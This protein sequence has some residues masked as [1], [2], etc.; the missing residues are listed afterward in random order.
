M[1]KSI[2]M[3]FAGACSYGILSTFVKLAYHEGY[4]IAEIAFLQAFLGMA[5]L[6]LLRLF[7]KKNK[8]IATTTPTKSVWLA[9]TLAG[10]ALGMTSFV[11]YLSVQY[12]PASIAIVALMQFTWI[13]ILLDW[14]FFRKTPTVLQLL[15]IA[16][17]LTGTIMASGM[18]S[19]QTTGLSVKGIVYALASAFLYGIYIV[20]SSKIKT[21]VP[22]LTKSSVM[23]MGSAVLLFTINA[24][25]LLTQSHFDTGLIKWVILLALFGTVIPPLLFSNGIPNIGAGYSAILMSAELPVA[26]ICSQLILKEHIDFYQWLGI[27]LILFSIIW[28]NRK[29]L[30]LQP[31]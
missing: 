12:I 14:V 27:L 28:M 4:S 13:G 30:Q 7:S 23:M 20:V 3:V 17:I 26:V 16:L 10:A 5:I 29:K 2:F 8:T 21:D 24:R 25:E 31:S 9:L 15:S 18:L 19:G 22:M 6:Y 1:T 11:Y